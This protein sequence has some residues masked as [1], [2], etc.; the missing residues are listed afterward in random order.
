MSNTQHVATGVRGL[1][2]NEILAAIQATKEGTVVAI[3]PLC[4]ALKISWQGQ[5]EKMV[6]NPRFNCQ[7]ILMVGADGK[8]RT[9]VCLPAE[10][11]ADWINSINSRKVA[12]EKAEAL[13]ELQKFFQFAINEFAR[14]R[15]VTAGEHNKV[16]AELRGVIADLSKQVQAL[17]NTVSSLQYI[18]EMQNAS[19][20][21]LASAAGHLMNRARMTKPLRLLQ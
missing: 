13:L 11:V 17:T 19:E 14:E 12:K 2:G 16:V 18:Q 1:K 10:Q 9:M 7:D 8:H 21:G 3:K 5:H 15:Y 6:G 20:R 4:V